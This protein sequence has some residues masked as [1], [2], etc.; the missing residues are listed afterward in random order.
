MN[1]IKLNGPKPLMIAHRGLSGLERENTCAAFIAAGNR[2]YFGIETDV[3]LTADGKYAVI[4]DSS[5][6][7]VSGVELTV[8]ETELD[9]LRQLQLLDLQT[10]LPRADL[11]IPTLEEYISVCKKY[12]KTAVLELKNRMP[13]EAIF[14]IAEIISSMGYMEHTVFISFKLENLI[15]LREKHPCQPAQYLLSKIEDADATLAVLLKHDLDLDVKYTAVTEELMAL[16]HGNGRKVN[17]WT[18][19]APEEAERLAKLGVD[20]ITTNILE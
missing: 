20:F 7:R 6:A 17:V 9:V 10:G 3:H 16:M 2:S 5:T 11:R 1:T 14:E 8:E 13:R 18:V 12:E 4:H 19:D 15:D